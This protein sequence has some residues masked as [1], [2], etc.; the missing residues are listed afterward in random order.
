MGENFFGKVFFAR[1][2]VTCWSCDS[3]T[4]CVSYRNNVSHL[5]GRTVLFPISD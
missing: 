4:L 1:T 2:P 5:C 3:E